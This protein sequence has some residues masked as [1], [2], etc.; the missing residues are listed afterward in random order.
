[1]T[2]IQARE[3][4]IEAMI[5]MKINKKNKRKDP[6]RMVREGFWLQ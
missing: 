6:E 3:S 2:I 4:D 5:A 1:V